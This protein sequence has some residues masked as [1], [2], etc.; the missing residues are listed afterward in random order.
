MACNVVY[1]CLFAV[2]IQIFANLN[3]DVVFGFQDGVS[4][5]HYA[6]HS[7]NTFAIKALLRRNADINASDNVG[8]YS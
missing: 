6:T 2:R 4:V 8:S 1:A 5:L 3:V 7:A